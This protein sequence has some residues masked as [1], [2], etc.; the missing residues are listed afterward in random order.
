MTTQEKITAL[1]EELNLHNYNYYVLDNPTISDYDFDIKLKEL[2]S[3]EQAH[4]EFFDVDSPTQRVGGMIT[5]NFTTVVHDHRMYSLENSYSKEDLLDW[6]QRLQKNLGDVQLEYTCELKY[7]G[8][9]ISI[10]YEN[11]ELVRAVTRGDGIQGDDVTS[12]IRTIRS[13]PIK[14]KGDFP[15]RFDI[16]GEIVLPF[17]G[18]EKMNQELMEIGEAP[19]SNPRNTASGSLK[20]QNSAE[21]AKRPLECLLYYIVGQDLGFESQ[22]KGLEKAREWG[23]KVPVVSQLANNIDEVFAF[24]AYWDEHRHEL[25]YETDGVVIKVNSLHYQEELGYTSKFP[26]WAIAY[27]FKAEQVETRL[28]SI[29]Y[30]VGRTGA[31]TPVANL[32]PVQLAGTIVKRA[33]LHNADQIAKLDIRVGDMV[34]VEKGGEIIPK[35][36]GIDLGVRPESLERT[37][38]IKECPECGSKLVRNEGE[39]Q[40]Y[41]LNTYGCP[42]QIAGRIQ[43][44]ITRKAMDIDGLGEETVVLLYKNGLVEN[45]ADLYELKKEQLLGLERMGEKS[46]DNL[47]KGIEMSKQVP[48]ERVLYALGIRFVGETVAKKLAIHYKSIDVLAQA[49]LME[50]VMVDEIGERI[51][52]SVIDFFSNEKNKENIK[53]LKTYGLQFVLEEK[54][55]TVVSEILKGKTVVVSGVFLKMS[56]DEMKQAIEDNGGKNGS[57]ISSKTDY[58]VAGDKMGPSKLEKATKLGITILNED[59]FL[60]MIQ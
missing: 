21:V 58:L 55:S 42:P 34:Y 23:F 39:A 38:Y 16:R 54:E 12:N 5:K 32:E 6:E 53:R 2:E 51:A 18:F 11:G 14:L 57:S 22:F 17:A 27:K 30:Q 47:L 56:R 46:A 52:Q 35:I 49:S 13:V 10:T 9:S 45:Y 28:N 37:I 43:H 7:D 25:P 40:H 60:S 26:R 41:C 31:I 48:F 1:R 24:I 44:F 33:S 59:E 36:V 8:A 3:L 19:Y 50:M 29:S 15:V 4:P 20:L